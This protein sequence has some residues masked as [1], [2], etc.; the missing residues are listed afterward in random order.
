MH[1][2]GP[3]DWTEQ[4]WYELALDFAHGR[5]GLLVDSDHYVAYFENAEQSDLVGRIGYALP[6]AGPTGIVAPNLW[7]WSMVMNAR[8]PHK[9]AAWELIQWATS[10]EFLLRSALEGNMN[11]TRA[12]VWDDPSF[13]AMTA[14]WGRFHEVSRRLVEDLGRVLVRPAVNYRDVASRWTQ[15][16]H[17]A[18]EGTA[19]VADALTAAG[20]RHR[21]DR[22]LTRRHAVASQVTVRQLR[23]TWVHGTSRSTRTSPGRPSTRSPRM[24]YITS[25]VP[26]SIEFARL[27]RKACCRLCDSPENRGRR[28]S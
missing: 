13:A 15:A 22:R 10:S 16:L 27:R 14:P 23:G 20:V 4:R 6:P 1:A 25:V 2:S 3:T 24:L 12:S 7:T 21:R 8:S 28:I 18:Y 9:D 11:P 5:Y 17:E 19:T 26:P